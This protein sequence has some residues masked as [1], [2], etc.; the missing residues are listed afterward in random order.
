[1]VNILVN[2]EWAVLKEARIGVVVPLHSVIFV[3]QSLDVP[4][5]TFHAS[6]P[7][8]LAEPTR[9][10]Q[11]FLPRK[12]SKELS[13]SDELFILGKYLQS[14]GSPRKRDDFETYP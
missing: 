1:M 4:V 3:P 10:L 7:D 14:A 8:C 6:F 2:L 9:S 12:S 11:H 13:I 5:S